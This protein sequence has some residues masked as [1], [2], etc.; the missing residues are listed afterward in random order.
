MNEKGWEPT[1]SPCENRKK[2]CVCVSGYNV[3][4][5]GDG[6]AALFQAQSTFQYSQALCQRTA[7]IPGSWEA[8]DLATEVVVVDDTEGRRSDWASWGTRCFSC[9]S[10]DPPVSPW[11]GLEVTPPTWPPPRAALVFLSN[12]RFWMCDT[13]SSAT[14][15]PPAVMVSVAW[16]VKSWSS[17]AHRSDTRH[18]YTPP[19]S[20]FTLDRLRRWEMA[21]PWTRTVWKPKAETCGS[22]TKLANV[23]ITAGFRSH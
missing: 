4:V 12:Q 11:L 7:A 2:N 6:T 16:T 9:P 20:F 15:P 13:A 14:M 22:I 1:Q 23:W 10:L 5:S 3:C 8:A 18:S 19:S 21:F 17:S